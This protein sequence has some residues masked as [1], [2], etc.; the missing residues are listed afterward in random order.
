MQPS[1]VPQPP[2][3]RPL[4]RPTLTLTAGPP[5]AGKS[6]WVASFRAEAE[7]GPLC[8]IRDEIRLE[9][10][11]SAYLDGDHNYEVEEAVTKALRDRARAALETGSD[12]FVD[13]CN[14]HPLTRHQWRLA[15]LDAGGAFR[16]MVFDLPL[17]EVLA[18]NAKRVEPRDTLKVTDAHRFW[19]TKVQQLL[20][21]P[22]AYPYS[23][24]H[25]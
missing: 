6:E 11:G 19:E 20:E 4:H 21:A 5:S 3:G 9:I 2:P 23:Q 24:Q 16:I 13:G 17:D 15:A 7:G 22:Y 25:G 10:G 18:I 1:P 8:L 14:N 12:V